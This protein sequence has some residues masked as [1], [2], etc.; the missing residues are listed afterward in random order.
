MK[1]RVG[2]AQ[3][4]LNEPEISSRRTDERLSIRASACVSA[5]CSQNLP[6]GASL[7]S[8]HIVADVEYIAMQNAI[9]ERRASRR[10]RHDED[11]SPKPPAKSGRRACRPWICHAGNGRDDRISKASRTAVPACA[12]SPSARKSRARQRRTGSKTSFS[13]PSPRKGCYASL[14]L[15]LETS[16]EHR[17]S[18]AGRLL[19]CSPSHDCMAWVP[20]SFIMSHDTA[21]NPLTGL[22]APAYDK[23]LEQGIAG[24]V[25][26]EKVQQALIT[27][28]DRLARGNAETTFD[29]S[30]EAS[31]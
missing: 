17:R 21:G 6:R 5:I 2:I 30:D 25:T 31:R 9:K 19:P 3:A 29:L 15:E 10:L 7:I 11:L 13:A 1:R 23:N 27:Y 14:A 12:I 22:D 18:I 28:Q 24:T 16:A 8:T 26:P 20:T 4:L